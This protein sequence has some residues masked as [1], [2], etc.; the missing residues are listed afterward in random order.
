MT[1]QYPPQV[2]LTRLFERRSAYGTR[3]FSGLLGFGKVILLPGKPADD[4]SPT[5]RLFIA[6]RAPAADR[7]A[8]PSNADPPAAR[9]APRRTRP[10]PKAARPDD[11]APM[12]DDPISDLWQGGAP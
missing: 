7:A 4:G 5:W 9:P 1:G 10:Q 3:Y 12:A 8:V 11:G 2:E 6:A